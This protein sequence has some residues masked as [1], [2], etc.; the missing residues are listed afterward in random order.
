MTHFTAPQWFAIILFT[1]EAVATV[2]AIRAK[3]Y[4]S[5]MG[6]IIDGV[7]WFIITTWGGFWD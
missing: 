5:A 3:G 4:N 1:S 2:R 7:T 6:Y